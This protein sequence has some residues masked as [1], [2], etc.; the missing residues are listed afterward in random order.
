MASNGL[1]RISSTPEKEINNIKEIIQ[2]LKKIKV[3]KWY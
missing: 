1:H 3:I 2:I